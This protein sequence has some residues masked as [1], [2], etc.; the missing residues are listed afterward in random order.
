VILLSAGFVT[1][2]GFAE[3]E[4]MIPITL[5]SVLAGDL[6]MYWLGHKF[7]TR[8][9]CWK[10]FSYFFTPARTDKIHNFYKRYGRATIF[11]GRFTPGIRS[12]LY[13]F[14]GISKMGVGRFILMDSLAAVISV[15]LLVWVGFH[16]D[17]EIKQIAFFIG[18]IKLWIFVLVAVGVV[19][20]IVRNKIKKARQPAQNNTPKEQG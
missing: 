5:V 18:R 4:L 10:P 14:A 1:A 19:Y 13:V 9:Y 6:M 11:V 8:I 15:P 16:F 7:G 3:L 20:I 17:Y 2:N 12:W